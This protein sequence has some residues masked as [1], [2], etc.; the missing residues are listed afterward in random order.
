MFYIM[1]KLRLEVSMKTGVLLVVYTV[2]GNGGVG[3]KG[4]Y[5]DAAGILLSATSLSTNQRREAREWP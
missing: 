4:V 3:S 2:V 5:L 1:L